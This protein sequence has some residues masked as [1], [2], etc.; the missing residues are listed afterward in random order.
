MAMQYTL[1]TP[2]PSA[3]IDAASSSASPDPYQKTK[4]EKK[5]LT[6]PRRSRQKTPHTQVERRYREHL[7]GQIDGLRR[8]VPSMRKRSNSN[9]GKSNPPTKAAIIEAAIEYIQ[10]LERANLQLQEQPK[11]WCNDWRSM[12]R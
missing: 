10:E 6:G 2:S 12:V 4:E 7:N 3:D 11:P 9:A 8:S 5:V 1:P